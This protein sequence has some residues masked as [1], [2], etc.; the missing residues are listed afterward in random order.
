MRD[1]IQRRVVQEHLP[2]PGCAT[3]DGLGVIGIIDET[4]AAKKGD[5]TPGVQH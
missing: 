2:A 5:K 3:A 1:R 4:S